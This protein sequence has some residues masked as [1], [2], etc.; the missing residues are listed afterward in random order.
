[1]DS[2]SRGV[3]IPLHQQ[4]HSLKYYIILNIFLVWMC[5]VKTHDW[6]NKVRQRIGQQA[7]TNEFNGKLELINDAQ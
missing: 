2:G 6:V 7:L 5:K 4:K 3:R 1:M